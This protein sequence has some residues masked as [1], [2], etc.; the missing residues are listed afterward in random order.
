[1]LLPSKIFSIVYFVME[2]LVYCDL[3][4]VYEK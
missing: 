1:M 3:R 4:T 2:E